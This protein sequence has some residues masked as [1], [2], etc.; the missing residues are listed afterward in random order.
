MATERIVPM[1]L[2]MPWP[3]ISGADPTK[4]QLAWLNMVERQTRDEKNERD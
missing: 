3:E 1:G 4:N 2:T